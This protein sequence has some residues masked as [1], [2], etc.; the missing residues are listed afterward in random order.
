M[1]KSQFIFKILFAVLFLGTSYATQAQNNV[2]PLEKF[3]SAGI[4]LIYI[5]GQY[6]TP[7]SDNILV[8]GDLA[9]A[10]GVRGNSESI[11]FAGTTVISGEARYMLNRAT[12]F[13]KG[14]NL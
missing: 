5:Y 13:E 4:G 9:Y 8:L 12:K 7:V 2:P 10:L 3:G 11:S 1:K 14:K 6:E